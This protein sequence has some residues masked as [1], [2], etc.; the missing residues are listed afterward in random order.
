MQTPMQDQRHQGSDRTVVTT[1]RGD[2]FLTA[3]IFRKALRIAGLTAVFT[4]VLAGAG[5]G[6]LRV[7]AIQEAL[8]A[9]T[10]AGNYEVG[11]K[12]VRLEWL[13]NSGQN[14]DC[15]IVGSSVV[16]EGVDPVAV[17]EGLAEA[18]G[19]A[20]RCF[21]DG[22]RGFR[23]DKIE[24][25]VDK[26]RETHPR[27]IVYGVTY[28]DLMDHNVAAEDAAAGVTFDPDAAT[29]VDTS[30]STP[31]LAELL[32]TYSY[33]YRY[34]G[35]FRWSMNAQTGA[36][37]NRADYEAALDARGFVHILTAWPHIERVPYPRDVFR[38]SPTVLGTLARTIGTGGD[39][40]MVVVVE[41]PLPPTSVHLLADDQAAYDRYIDAVARVAEAQHIPFLRSMPLDMI[42]ADGWADPIHLNER[43]ARVFSRWLGEM[44]AGIVGS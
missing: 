5:E 44:L 23:I 13:Q 32:N 21:N 35:S 17:E 34:Y 6:L 37:K 4:A 20:L 28:N 25:I 12:Q 26:R 11:A 9:P 7:R 14:V 29:N 42:P 24:T 30:E 43:G 38:T 18:G 31:G 15:F 33:L 36:L 41:V 1:I 16:V 40:V 10:V 39:P 3:V 19:P 2:G 8:P 27:V 22:V